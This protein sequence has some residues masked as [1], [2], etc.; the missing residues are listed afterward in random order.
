MSDSSRSSKDPA[1]S[2]R[3]AGDGDRDAVIDEHRTAAS[4][5]RIAVSEL[6]QRIV[7]AHEARTMADLENLVD[8]LTDDSDVPTLNLRPSMGTLKQTGKWIVPQHIDASCGLFGIEIDFTEA[9]CRHRE[10]SVTASCGMGNIVMIVPRGWSVDVDGSSVNTAHI[11]NHA[12]DP[13]DPQAPHLRVIGRAGS[14]RIRIRHPR[15]RLLLTLTR[16]KRSR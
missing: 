1:R 6:E 13:P 8:D 10:V 7:L 12:T 14:G 5:G 4:E 9:I 11:R 16:P 2:R 15:R 3:R